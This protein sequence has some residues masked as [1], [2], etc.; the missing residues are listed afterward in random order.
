MANEKSTSYRWVVVTLLFFATTI[1]YID[2]Q[3]IGLLKDYLAKDFNWTESDYSNIVIWFNV[4][5]AMGNVLFGIVVDRVG[6][7]IGYAASI[8]FWSLAA[9]AHSLVKSTGGFVGARIGL[10]L[11]EGGNFPS[12][13]RC[14]TE[15]FPKKQRA[16]ATGIFNSGTNIAAVISPG[17][18]YF[19]YHSYGWRTA[20]FLTG[21]IG[22]VWLVFWLVF[23]E[24]PARQKRINQ[25]EFDYIHSGD[26]DEEKES[27]PNKLTWGR[28][29]GV[30]QTWAFIIGKFFTD[31]VW[32]F[33]LFWIPSYFNTTYKI[34][35]KSSWV[36]V[37][38]IYFVATFGS[39][40]GGYLSGWFMK[41]GWPVYKARKTAMFLYALCVLPVF[42]IQNTSNPWSAVCLVSLAAAAHQAWSAN[43]FTTASDMFP[44]KA[45][46]SVIGLG[47]MAGAMGNI[48]FPMLIGSILDHFKVLGKITAGY[49]II[50]VICSC[51]YV[52]AWLLMHL[53]SPTMKRVV[54]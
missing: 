12:A 23:Y 29:L 34:D 46:S 48:L 1:N 50:F 39:V 52:L 20:F 10:G 41:Q 45:I 43:I 30:R 47:N 15:W 18:I 26:A 25:A 24:V 14:V 16:F 11:G 28:L 27:G 3:I 17:V 35:L 31:P 6:S 51:A 7:K 4:A 9:A 44:K 2:R 49:N 32:W 36:Y 8:V 13:I 54:A 38:T 53:L 40:F 19:I 37:S 5:Y 21:I 33:Y 22:F 42:F